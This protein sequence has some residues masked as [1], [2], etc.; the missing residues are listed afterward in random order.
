[1][2]PKGNKELGVSS[3]QAVVLLLFNDLA[4]GKTLSYAEIQGATGLCMS[5]LATP[6]RPSINSSC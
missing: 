2:F 4:D 1:M 3:F 5:P 6:S